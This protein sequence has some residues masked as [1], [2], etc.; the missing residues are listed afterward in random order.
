MP[1]HF[2]LHPVPDVR[3]VPTRAAD[4]EVVHVAAQDRVDDLDDPL[5]GLRAEPL[6]ARAL[7]RFRATTGPSSTLSPSVRLPAWYRL[8]VLPCSVVFA[9]GRAGLLQLLGASL[10]PCWRY[11]PARVGRRSQT[12]AVHAAFASHS[13][14]RPLGL[15]FSRLPPRSLVFR[16]GDLLTALRRLLSMGFRS[17]VCPAIQLRGSLALCA[18][19]RPGA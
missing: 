19:G 4:G 17:C 18:S 11:H 14:A 16:P 5:N 15:F 12:R 7:P 3:K 13:R 10:S 1:P 2:L 6:A 9:T 8:C